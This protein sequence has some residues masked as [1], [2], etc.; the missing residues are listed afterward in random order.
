VYLT[1]MLLPILQLAFL[2]VAGLDIRELDVIRDEST[3]RPNIAYRVQEYTR[4]E[5]DITLVYLVAAKRA[6]YS[7]EAQILIYCPTVGETKR[8][9]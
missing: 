5:L 2:D 8:L 7:V 1:A 6:K 3:T 9:G 4:G